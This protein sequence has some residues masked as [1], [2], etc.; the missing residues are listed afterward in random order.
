MT[1]FKRSLELQQQLRRQLDGVAAPAGGPEALEQSAALDGIS[2]ELQ[3]L[4]GDVA[5]MKAKAQETDPAK[6]VLL[7]LAF[8]LL[9]IDHGMGS[10]VSSNVLLLVLKRMNAEL[11]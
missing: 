11:R 4:G 1:L 7:A 8:L 10:I 9:H 2:V 5:K 6:K 3:R